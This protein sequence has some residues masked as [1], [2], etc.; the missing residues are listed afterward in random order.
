MTL[1][2]SVR[3][4]RPASGPAVEPVRRDGSLAREVELEPDAGE[5]RPE[6]VVQVAPQP[7][8]LL[9]AR[10]HDPAAAP[11]EQVDLEEPVPD[12]RERERDRDGQHQERDRAARRRADGR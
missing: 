5:R 10:R 9:L 4:S 6:P 12:D 3:G 11:R 1:R 2:T 8:P 7:P